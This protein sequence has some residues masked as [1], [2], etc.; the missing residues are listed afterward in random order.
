[1]SS[2]NSSS[3][4]IEAAN[5]NNFVGRINAIF[6]VIEMSLGI[7]LN[8]V[9][10]F[11]FFRLMRNKTNMGFL[12]IIQCITDLLILSVFSVLYRSNAYLFQTNWINL[13]NASCKLLSF[14]RRFMVHMSSWMRVI[15][16]LDRFVFILFGYRNHFR[17]M[18]SKTF[19]TIFILIV[20]FFLAVFDIPN[21]FFYL[22]I[23]STCTADYSI[24]VLSDMTSILFRTY[25]PFAIMLVLNISMMLT[26]AKV[27][28]SRGIWNDSVS[29]REYKFTIAVIVF[30][31]SFFFY[32]FPQSIYFIFN[33][34]NLYSGAFADPLFNAKYNVVYMVVSNLSFLEQSLS[35]FMFFG[36]N[37]VFRNELLSLFKRK[38][39]G[40]DNSTIPNEASLNASTLRV[41]MKPNLKN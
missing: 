9:S 40:F 25:L 30:D 15:I 2:Q 1:M 20:F 6:V 24:I 17:H 27:K 34:I 7:P 23:K 21:L 4:L 18:K 26:I 22:N 36:F 41:S 35:F 31:V 39:I 38:R 14:L 3:S 16:T 10:M 13:S 8:L 33:D 29:R 32:N 28:R 12:G 37:K 19:L 11:I 5:L